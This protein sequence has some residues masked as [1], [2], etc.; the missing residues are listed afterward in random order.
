VGR[1]PAVAPAA[2]DG[3]HLHR[4]PARLLGGQLPRV[5]APPLHARVRCAQGGWRCMVAV[6]LLARWRP[7]K[8]AD[9]VAGV[10]MLACI[11]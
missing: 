4:R 8:H 10:C 6:L 11:A 9:A 5:W 7:A 2:A 3:H 1:H